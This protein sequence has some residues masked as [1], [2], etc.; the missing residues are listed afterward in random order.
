MLIS[1]VTLNRAVTFGEKIEGYSALPKSTREQL[2]P[3][4]D[5]EQLADR[6]WFVLGRYDNSLAVTTD[7]NAANRTKGVLLVSNASLIG[8]VENFMEDMSM[9]FQS[10]DIPNTSA[11]LF[12]HSG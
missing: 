3:I 4:V 5:K 11:K 1:P 12:W 2:Q 7:T 10:T 8:F 6:D 9:S